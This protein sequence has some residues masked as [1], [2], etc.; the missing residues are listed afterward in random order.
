MATSHQQAARLPDKGL[1]AKDA[2]ARRFLKAGW[3]IPANGQ[4]GQRKG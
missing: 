3:P 1:H 4:S 2:A